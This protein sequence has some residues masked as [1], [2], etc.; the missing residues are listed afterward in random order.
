MRIAVGHRLFYLLPAVALTA[1]ACGSGALSPS[2]AQSGLCSADVPP[3]QECT[4]LH[5]VAAPVK[6]TCV[7]GTLPTGIGGTILDGTYVLTSQTY[8]NSGTGCPTLAVSLTL[9]IAGDC[10]QSVFTSD[11]ES[12]ALSSR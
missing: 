7:S 6:P 9:V 12:G 8:Y 10:A 5:S 11:I 4:A 3:G 2:G 1:S